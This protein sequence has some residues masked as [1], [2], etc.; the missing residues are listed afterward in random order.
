MKAQVT[1]SATDSLNDWLAFALAGLGITFAPH[2]YVGG[3]F[4]AGAGALIARH[5]APGV[6]KKSVLMVLLAA[7]FTS[8]VLAAVSDIYIPHVPHQIVMAATGFA[9]TFLV[10]FA[11]QVAGKIE[12][13]ADT[14]AAKVVDKVF[15]DK[16]E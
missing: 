13:R 6:E 7:F 1:Q 9:S 8:T 3:L 5:W 11:L 16:D 15:P 4:L 2:A 12:T 10:R 14:I